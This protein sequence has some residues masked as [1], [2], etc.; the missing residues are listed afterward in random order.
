MTA[1]RTRL[2]SARRY[3]EVF[4]ESWKADHDGAMRCPDFEETLVEAV[5]VFE[6][7]DELVQWRRECVFRGVEET[8]ER[9]GLRLQ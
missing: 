9:V 5:K 1:T 8:K 6:L 3:L 4:E 2:A 7:V